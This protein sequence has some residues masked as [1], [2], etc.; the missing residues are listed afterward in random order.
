M[1]L[2]EEVKQTEPECV[3][4]KKTKHA[5]ASG[6]YEGEDKDELCKICYTQELG[7]EH[8]TK[9]SCGHIFHTNCIVQLLQQ[10]WATL[11]DLLAFMSCP[12][13]KHELEI[14]EHTCSEVVEELKPLL[15]MKKEVEKKA[16]ENAEKRGLLQDERLSNDKFEYGDE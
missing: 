1:D 12:N 4:C 10:E 3:P 6:I 2:T 15:A 14:S 9:L 7:A 8:C 13:C 5:K 16:L 11:S